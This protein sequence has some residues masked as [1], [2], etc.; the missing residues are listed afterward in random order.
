MKD[1]YKIHKIEDIIAQ[2]HGLDPFE[3]QCFYRIYEGPGELEFFITPKYPYDGK[4]I[5]N[6][7]LYH[8]VVHC[9]TGSAE[10][11]ERIEEG[12]YPIN[13]LT[14]WHGLEHEIITETEYR[15]HRPR[16][17]TQSSV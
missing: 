9:M 10:K 13:T 8:G 6:A 14:V 16:L 11:F 5:V 12:R 3:V 7:V 2:R 4:V 1:W 17:K 15:E